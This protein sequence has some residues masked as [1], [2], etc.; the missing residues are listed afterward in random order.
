MSAPGGNVRAEADSFRSTAARVDQVLAEL[1]DWWLRLCS[2]AEGYE[3][4]LRTC[5]TQVGATFFNG[6]GN[7]PGY[8]A[9]VAKTL[10]SVGMLQQV[11][12]QFSQALRDGAANLTE[13]EI[14][15]ADQL[16]SAAEP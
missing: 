14:T 4:T 5:P 12:G 9:N 10:N 6:N 3:A 8:T 2:D 13:M 15:N 11:L 16:R 7:D 1:N